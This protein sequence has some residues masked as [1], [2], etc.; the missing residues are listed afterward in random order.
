MNKRWWGLLVLAGFVMLPIAMQSGISSLKT[1]VSVNP[2]LE[3]RA[4]SRTIGSFEFSDRE[5]NIVTL[6]EMKGRHILLNVWATW[7]PP[8]RKEMPSLDRL[9]PILERDTDITVMALSVDRAG[10]EQLQ[11]FYNT[12]GLKN[13][14]LYRG[15]EQ[16]VLGALAI[17]GLPTT[18]LLDHEGQE[19]ARLIGPTDWDAT[20]VIDNL[21]AIH[22]QDHGTST[23]SQ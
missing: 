14:A 1:Y 9:K 17:S 10:F 15:D 12:Y 20:D 18:L 3:V 4:H 6:S 16:V 11:A 5:G 23:V 2:Y 7:C 19:V 8:C 13:L 22:R 21:K